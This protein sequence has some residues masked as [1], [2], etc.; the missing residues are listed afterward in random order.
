MIDTANQSNNSSSPPMRGPLA[1]VIWACFLGCSWTWVIGMYFPVLLLKDYGLLGWVAF[2]LPNVVGAAA[3]GFVLKNPD[4]SR[5]IV[6]KHRAACLV[7]SQITVAY[8]VYMVTAYT[9]LIAWPILMVVAFAFLFAGRSGTTRDGVIAAGVWAVSLIAFGYLQTR[10]WLWLNAGRSIHESQLTGLDLLLFAPASLFGFALCPY[11]DL[12]FHRARQATDPG[13]GRAAFALGFGVVFFSMIVFSL[14]YAGALLWPFVD[15]SME[16][17]DGVW[18]VFRWHLLIQAAFTIAVHWRAMEVSAGDSGEDGI[19]G[20]S[21]RKFGG[22]S[23]GTSGGEGYGLMRK[24]VLALTAGLLALT[25]LKLGVDHLYEANDARFF[26]I[27]EL[28]YRSFLLLYGTAFPAYVFLCMIPTFRQV[29]HNAKVRVFVPVALLS[30]LLAYQA[31][32]AA[33]SLWVLAILALMVGARI[34][35]ELLPVKSD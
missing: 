28:V 19:V 8:Q 25:A 23:R 15:R 2:A 14:A 16:V 10:G 17:Y 7:F 24:L 20:V 32:I 22:E 12:T 1:A 6:K 5:R 27:T 30:Y 31:F 29:S 34:L 3:M 9:G 18:Q 21:V 26:S 4:A 11:L 35:I 33:Q 13:T